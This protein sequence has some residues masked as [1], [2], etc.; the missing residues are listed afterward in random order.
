MAQSHR[1]SVPLLPYAVY[2]VVRDHYETMRAEC[3]ASG[4]AASPCPS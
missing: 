2:Q 3:L 4:P 1:D